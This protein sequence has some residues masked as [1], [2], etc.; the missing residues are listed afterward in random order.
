MTIQEHQKKEIQAALEVYVSNHKNQ[1]QAAKSLIN[2]SEAT[3]IQIKQGKFNS[4]SDAMW[5]NI[6]KQIGLKS[7]KWN[8]VMTK[9]LKQ[10]VK[11]FSKVRDNSL[12][13]AVAISA[14]RCK[15][16]AA[17][18]FAKHNENAFHIVCAEYFSN[19]TLLGKILR[20][21]NKEAD[22]SAADMME[23]IIETVLRMDNPIIILDEFDKLKDKQKLFFI[24]LFNMLS[25]HCAL[26]IMGTLN[27]Q[28]QILRK[29]G[30][31][32]IGYE[33]IYSRIGRRF[34]TLKDA[35]LKDVAQICE[36]NG[37]TDPQRI[38]KIFNEANGDLR[39]VKTAVIK[40]FI[41]KDSDESEIHSEAA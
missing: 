39:R 8:V 36:A 27:M 11:L 41:L 5:T 28:Y 1:S 21:M 23:L 37:V 33:E 6:A 32:V 30:K 3:I 12:T 14:G 9:P 20:S 18:W 31:H 29:N 16:E 19:K 26:V 40:E 7:S 24:T 4:I 17:K 13:I 38:T 34:I 35:D 2:V 22:G 25:D 10:L 15:S